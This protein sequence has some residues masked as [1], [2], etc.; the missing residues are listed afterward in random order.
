MN[1]SRA[2]LVIMLLLLAFKAPHHIT[3]EEML[4]A[5]YCM[6]I[7]VFNRTLHV[8]YEVERI[9][10]GRLGIKIKL[11]IISD[12]DY[13]INFKDK[14]VR[15]NYIQLSLY[16]TPYIGLSFD[17]FLHVLL[18]TPLNAMGVCVSG[19]AIIHVLQQ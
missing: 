12:G 1:Y 19:E 3:Q 11:N 8:E 6:T 17:D 15:I 10:D 14:V 13:I 5:P 7:N 9:A 18:N 4:H 2:L 16:I